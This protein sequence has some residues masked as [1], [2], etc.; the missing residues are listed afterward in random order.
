[1][2]VALNGYFWNKPDTGSGQYT[3]QLVYHLNRLVSDLE[4]TLV[5]PTTAADPTPLD[6]PPSVRVHLVPLRAGHVGKVWFEQWQFPRACG[7]ISA[8]IAHVPYWGAPLRS[9]VPL[10]V[11][12]HDLITMIVPAYHNTAA[13]RLY[14]A[15][16]AASARGANHVITD[17]HASKADI[18]QLLQ[19]DPERVTPIYLGIGPQFTPEDNFLLD[20]AV[21]QKYNLPESYV[22]Y[23]GGFALH[24]NVHQLLLAF[25][26]VVQGLGGDYPLVLAGRKPT[27]AS[28]QFP[29]YEAYIQKLGLA[30]HVRWIGFVEEADKPVIYRSAASFV[31]PSRYEGFGF[32]PLEAMACNV[33]VVTTTAPGVAEVIGDAALAVDPDD[34]RQMGGAIIATLIQDNLAQELRAKGQA[35]AREFTWEQTV[36]RTLAVYAD[37]LG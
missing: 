9:S 27:A 25:T 14:N 32:P 34:E 12:I 28:P 1:M 17:S 29:D 2:H 33:P 31:F 18:T 5:F 11:T 16:V 37:V 13:S 6:V 26:Y 20:M 22:L 36:A 21:R 4:L 35:R 15:L 3:R 23:L 10:V 24:K 30:E 19:I 8:D 7:Q